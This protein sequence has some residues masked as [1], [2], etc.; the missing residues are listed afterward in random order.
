MSEGQDCSGLGCTL[1]VEVVGAKL[2]R[3][4]ILGLLN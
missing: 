4:E 3:K 2:K 1:V